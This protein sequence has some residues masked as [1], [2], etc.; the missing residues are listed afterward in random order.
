MDRNSMVT[1]DQVISRT[2]KWIKKTRNTL[3]SRKEKLRHVV[4]EAIGRAAGVGSL[5]G[6]QMQVVG[7]T[8]WGGDVPQSDLDV[9]LLTPNG[10]QIGRKAVGVLRELAKHLQSC[11]KGY[12]G[13]HMELLEACKVPVLK[14]VDATGLK[15]DITVDQHNTLWLRDHLRA[16]LAKGRPEVQRMVRLVK[17][18]LHSRG[19][20]T[21]VEGGFSSIAWSMMAVHFADEQPG[22]MSLSQLIAAFFGTMHRL[23]QDSLHMSR[24]RSKGTRFQ[25]TFR[26]GGAAAWSSEWL[27]MLE[28]EDPCIESNFHEG[29]LTPASL[30]A[31]VCLLYAAELRLTVRALM[32]GRYQDIWRTATQSAG[33]HLLPS[34][35][36]E[37]ARRGRME[38]HAVLHSGRIRCGKLERVTRQDESQWLPVHRREKQCTLLLSPWSP[39]DQGKNPPSNKAWFSC[40]PSHWIRALETDSGGLTAQ[41][42]AA[43]AALSELCPEPISAVTHWVPRPLVAVS[44]SLLDACRPSDATTWVWQIAANNA[45]AQVAAVAAAQAALEAPA[46]VASASSSASRNRA[47]TSKGEANCSLPVQREALGQLL[48]AVPPTVPPTAAWAQHEWQLHGACSGRVQQHLI[49]CNKVPAG[50][51]VQSVAHK[52]DVKQ[53]QKKEPIGALTDGKNCAPCQQRSKRSLKIR[54]AKLLREELNALNAASKVN[55]VRPSSKGGAEES[56]GLGGSPRGEAA[57]TSRSDESTRA[58]DSDAE[59]EATRVAGSKCQCVPQQGPKLHRG[60]QQCQ[61]TMVAPR[62]LATMKLGRRAGSAPPAIRRGR[63]NGRGSKGD[64]RRLHPEATLG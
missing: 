12:D 37:V 23:G 19:L 43:L 46:A 56:D 41:G 3:K 26:G 54:N 8:S 49:V 33:L 27:T 50:T 2:E 34:S 60:W 21:A 40:R 64:G 14:F 1:L 63:R 24:N 58:T 29:T 36:K 39:L 28:V 17:L 4:W 11:M 57:G 35:P 15:C 6:C 51:D 45:F 31:A 52:L 47:S 9:V 7:S 25:W 20:P 22:H 61:A 44:C 32:E 10:G 53:E 38:V 55:S 18:W 16:A 48:K 30:P 5:Q 62:V 42:L 13:W 59:S